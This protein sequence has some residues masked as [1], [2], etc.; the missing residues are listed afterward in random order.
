MVL[1]VV[2]QR[3]VTKVGSCQRDVGGLGLSK[4]LLGVEALDVLGAPLGFVLEAGICLLVGLLLHGGFG[5][6][7]LGLR[8]PLLQEEI[9]VVL[10]ILLLGIVLR[11][12]L[13]VVLVIR[14][15]ALRLRAL[16]DLSESG[17]RR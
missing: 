3:V 7:L 12:V 9:L 1:D 2:P 8:S 17:R 11:A 4:E 15:V 16:D 10:V 6:L 13:G 5:V 14:V